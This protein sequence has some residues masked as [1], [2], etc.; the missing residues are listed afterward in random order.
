V[1]GAKAPCT[2]LYAM[3]AREGE[4]W[5]SSWWRC[6]KAYGDD[7]EER[8]CTAVTG[9]RKWLGVRSFDTRDEVFGT[10][11]GVGA[12]FESAEEKRE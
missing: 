7:Q 12:G 8:R 11:A 2:V 1:D 4:S 3:S 5:D 9:G 10:A 6:R